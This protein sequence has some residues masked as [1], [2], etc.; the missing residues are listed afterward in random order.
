MSLHIGASAAG[1][2]VWGIVVCT[3]NFQGKKAPLRHRVDGH[4][5]LQLTLGAA[6]HF[7]SEFFS[8][9]LKALLLF[10]PAL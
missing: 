1:F 5:R 9:L 10:A 7:P 6:L 2:F 4:V 8:A 3:T